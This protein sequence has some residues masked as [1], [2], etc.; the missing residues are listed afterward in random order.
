MN[1]G[2]FLEFPRREN[3]TYQEAFQEGFAL[4][5]EA[6]SQ[7]VQSVWLAEYHF[8]AGR[9]RSAPITIASALAARTQNIRIGLAVHILPL[10]NPVRIAEEIATLDHISEGR[11]EFGVGRGRRKLHQLEAPFVAVARAAKAPRVEGAPFEMDGVE[12]DA[13]REARVGG[14]VQGRI[15]RERQYEVA[16]PVGDRR[17]ARRLECR[18]R[19]GLRGVE[20]QGPR[21]GCGCASKH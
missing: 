19:L 6:E 5:D 11:I 8:N 17:G 12:V 2:L 4:V 9:V 14:H 1:V 21:A 13:G 7:G 15:G 3:G 20:Q 18:E 16:A 10:G